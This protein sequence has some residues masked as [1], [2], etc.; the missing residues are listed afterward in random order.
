VATYSTTSDVLTLA[1]AVAATGAQPKAFWVDQFGH[2]QSF[3]LWNI[4][5][6]GTATSATVTIDGSLDG[7]NW[8][9]GATGAATYTSGSTIFTP[10]GTANK[11]FPYIRAN[12]TAVAGGNVT[13]LAVGVA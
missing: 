8:Q 3:S 4:Q 6:S 13:V 5:T 2:V 10:V 9:L 1:N 7:V 12:I 11:A